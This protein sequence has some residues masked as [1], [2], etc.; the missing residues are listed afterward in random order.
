M[1]SLIIT[2]YKSMIDTV[3]Y[4]KKF[5]DIYVGNDVHYIIVDNSEEELGKNR[6]SKNRILD[7]WNNLAKM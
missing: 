5:I 6:T 4:I 3:D 1:Y 7:M 2:D